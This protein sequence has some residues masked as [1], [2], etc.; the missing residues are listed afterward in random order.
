MRR[1]T[2]I[3]FC[4]LILTMTALGQGSKGGDMV[5]TNKIIGFAGPTISVGKVNNQLAVWWGAKG[6]FFLNKQ[7]F[8]GGYGIGLGNRVEKKIMGVV[9]EDRTTFI[10]HGGLWMG[11]VLFPEKKI[12]FNSSLQLGWG[13]VSLHESETGKMMAYNE[14][15]TLVPQLELTIQ[16]PRWIKFSSSIGYSWV[17]KTHQPNLEAKDYR[18]PIGS[19]S[20]LIGDFQKQSSSKREPLVGQIRF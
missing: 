1:F 6:A 12:H 18:T 11:Y 2:I 19:F 15:F 3:V 7:F 14:I 13:G 5:S 9:V 10:G 17:S 8:F 16:M 4:S 20:I